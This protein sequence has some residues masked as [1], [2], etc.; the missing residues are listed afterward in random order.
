M[1]QGEDIIGASE[2][3]FS[4]QPLCSKRSRLQQ[5][6]LGALLCTA[7][8]DELQVRSQHRVLP[9]IG[10]Q[11]KTDS[12]G[13]ASSSFTA[14]PVDP[15]GNQFVGEITATLANLNEAGKGHVLSDNRLKENK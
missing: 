7:V 5:T 9:S 14:N 13:P 3:P 4:A 15:P 11:R 6:T 2:G 12:V 1:F 8:R 10:R